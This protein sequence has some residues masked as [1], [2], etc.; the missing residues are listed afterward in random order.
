MKKVF[1][2]VAGFY[3]LTACR[4]FVYNVPDITDYRIFDKKPLAK[5]ENP[6]KI[7]RDIRATEIPDERFWAVSNDHETFAT[8]MSAEDFLVKKGTES[9]IIIKNDTIVYERYFN[10]RKPD[11]IQTVFSVTK[12]FVSALTGI[13]I[14]EGKIKGVDQPVSDFIPEFSKGSLAKIKISHLLNMTSGLNESDYGDMV[15][16]S[17][18][19]YAKDHNKMVKKLK[20]RYEPGTHFQ[21]SSMCTQLLGMCLEQATGRHLDDYLREKIWDPMGMEV[22]GSISMD[23]RGH[24]K[25]FGGIATTPIDLAKFGLMYLHG[26]KWNGKQI[27]PED[28]VKLSSLRDTINGRSS[29]YGNCFWQDTYPLEDAIHKNDFFAGGYRG[30]IIYVNPDNNTV[31][32][33]TGVRDADVHWGRSLS[34][35][36]LF[37]FENAKTTVPNEQL[38]ASSGWYKNKFGKRMTF[39]YAEGKVVIGKENGSTEFLASSPL[40]FE[41][42]STG[43]KVMLHL[44]RNRVLGFI[45]EKGRESYYFSKD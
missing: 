43:E 8:E 42:K 24:A 25:A 1:F 11:G 4:V 14:A 36:A 38:A 18:F 16:L 26:G 9:L 37:P 44:R 28:W 10:G 40:T 13:A 7:V 27:V 39:S 19:Y 35:L 33:R 34:K 30:Q 45:L 32:I 3:V 29:A 12:S 23:R 31:I 6:S 21:Y 17:L 15:K 5:S 41:N 22:S 2:A 20:S